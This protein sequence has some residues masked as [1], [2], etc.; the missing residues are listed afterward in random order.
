VHF[1]FL[2]GKTPPDPRCLNQDSGQ[3]A[4]DALT[5]P[6]LSPLTDS[7]SQLGGRRGQSVAV[8]GQEE[9]RAASEVKLSQLYLYGD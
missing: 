9:N 5:T 7:S 8:S 4:P 2:S 6:P 3:L 1:F